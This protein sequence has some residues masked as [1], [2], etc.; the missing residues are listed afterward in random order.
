M[1]ALNKTRVMQIGV[2]LAAI[3]V[4][5]GLAYHY[6][7]RNTGNTGLASGNGRIEAT[8][9]VVATR[10]GGRVKDM[11]VN[12]GDFVKAGQVV[13]R[14]DSD[15]LN[16]QLRQAQSQAQ[17]AANAIDI[18]RSQHRQYQSEKAALHATVLQ[19]QAELEAAVS[20]EARSAKLVDAG[21]IT[22]QLSEDDLTRVVSARAAL[23]AA[24][25]QEAA[26]DAAIATGRAQVLGAQ[27]ALQAANAAVQRLQADLAD[28]VLV[29]PRDGR[30]QYRVAQMGEVVAAGGRVLNMIDLSDVYMTFFLPSASVGRIALGSEVRL[31]LDAAPN[32]VIPARASY[33]ADVAQFTPKTVETAVEREKLMFRVKAQIDPQ[34]LRQHLTQVKTGLPGVA[35]VKLD[36][37][38]AWPASLP[39]RMAK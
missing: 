14:I 28:N 22:R 11:L 33:I 1:V 19:R 15:A 6:W 7:G 37:K 31:V 4:A 35:W 27:S 23:V 9:I 2:T 12:E 38:A 17:Q 5:A 8:E 39:A 20:R 3:V 16:A 30:I 18:A 25:A 29:A 21:A 24:M 13:A 34:L 36:D 32:L 10:A 26:A